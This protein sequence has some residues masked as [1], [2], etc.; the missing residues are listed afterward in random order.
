[1]R[2]R[3]AVVGNNPTQRL[4]EN[5]CTCKIISESRQHTWVNIHSCV[6]FRH[7]KMSEPRLAGSPQRTWLDAAPP[8][9][10]GFLRAVWGHYYGTGA[11]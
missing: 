11:L 10:S 4:V 9:N 2:R 6:L 1:M 7:R 5:V 8:A 3:G